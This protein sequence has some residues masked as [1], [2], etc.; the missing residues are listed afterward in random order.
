MLWLV[1]FLQ[2][3]QC[4]LWRKFHNQQTSLQAMFS[5][6]FVRFINPRWL[7]QSL[8]NLIPTSLWISPVPSPRPYP[9]YFG[10]TTQC[11]LAKTQELASLCTVAQRLHLIIHLIYL[12]KPFFFFNGFASYSLLPPSPIRNKN[13][14]NFISDIWEI[15]MGHRTRLRE[16]NKRASV[17]D[18]RLQIAFLT[19]A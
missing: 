11:L 18:V 16:C 14:T 15:G 5:P 12:P 19:G 7:L 1:V 4:S 8:R 3:K 6:Y 10:D 9:T 2:G 17:K 13:R